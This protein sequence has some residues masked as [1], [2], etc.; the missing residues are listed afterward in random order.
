MDNDICS[1]NFID[2]KIQILENLKKNLEDF[3]NKTIDEMIG[4]RTEELKRQGVDLSQPAVQK[5]IQNFRQVRLA[6]I[7]R[8]DIELIEKEIEF[9]KSKKAGRDLG[10]SHA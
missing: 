8:H 3:L 6:S 5:L 7:G 1:N 9:Y 2:E 4:K 10:D